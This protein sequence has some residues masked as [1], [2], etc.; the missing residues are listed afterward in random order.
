MVRLV[1]GLYFFFGLVI[2]SFGISVAI[3]VKYL[4]I[5]PWDVLNVALYEKFGFTIGTWNIICGFTLVLISFIIDRRYINVGTFLNAVLVGSL[6]DFFLWS[7]ILP[8]A[9]HSWTDYVMIFC[10]ILIMGIG[11]GLYN[12]AGIGS[13]PRDGFMLSISD[14]L[15]WSITKVRIIVESFVLIIGFLLGGPVFIVTFVFTF[16]QSPVF[17]RSYQFFRKLLTTLR[18]RKENLALNDKPDQKA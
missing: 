6:V 10:G 18:K 2:F 17:A 4:G 1:Q 7:D 11:G 12:A 8:N 16:I 14:K 15:R 3:K 9:T 5:H 13:G